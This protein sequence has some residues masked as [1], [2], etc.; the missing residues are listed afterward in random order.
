LINTLALVAVCALPFFLGEA[1]AVY[2]GVTLLLGAWFVARAAGFLRAASRDATARKLFL[3]SILWLPL[4]LA[5][6][7]ADRLI[8]HP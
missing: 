4:Q 6:L 3:A 8:F 5:V 7:V 2:L 1:T